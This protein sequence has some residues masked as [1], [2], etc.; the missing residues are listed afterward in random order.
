MP[1]SRHSFLVLDSFSGS[2]FARRGRKWN[3]RSFSSLAEDNM[4]SLLWSVGTLAISVLLTPAPAGAQQ[5]GWTA[6]AGR[7]S[8]DFRDV[9]RHQRPVDASPMSWHGSG[10]S[11]L[12]Q[13][14]RFTLKRSHRFD[15]AYAMARHFSYR[16][17]LRS[18]SAAAGDRVA[19]LDV[20][21]EYRRYPF[22]DLRIRGFDVGL[23][24][25]GMAGRL[26]LQREY[27]PALVTRDRRSR[28]ALG[29][30]VAARLR[31]W[32]RFELE[33]W[34]T[35]GIAVSHRRAEEG[36]DGG[37]ASTGWGGGWYDEWWA[38]GRVRIT[39]TTAVVVE[40]ALARE[41]FSTTHMAHTA[42]RR[43]LLMG[44]AYAR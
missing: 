7:Y 21:Y 43:S 29:G 41:Y 5:T 10:P 17:P 14:E 38:T 32:R 28:F 8:F 6:S 27:A 39:T 16:S 25:A 33:T 42:A 2:P 31:R 11:L 12:L 22:T 35:N 44:V 15:L 19:A 20:S 1:E 26:A 40:H 34:W 30:V 3:D 18:F 23:G 13:H 9:S 37:T 36:I 4:R 24:A